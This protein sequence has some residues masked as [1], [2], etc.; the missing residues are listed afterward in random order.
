MI[1]EGTDHTEGIRPSAR[2]C[3]IP[4]LSG[5]LCIAAGVCPIQFVVGSTLGT[6]AGTVEWFS[7]CGLFTVGIVFDCG[8]W[9][10]TSCGG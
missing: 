5:E 2:G 10:T 7:A 3:P 1:H 9:F 6:M 4:V 8:C